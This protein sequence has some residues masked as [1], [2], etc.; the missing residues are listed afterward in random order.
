MHCAENLAQAKKQGSRRQTEQRRTEGG[1]RGAG[2]EELSWVLRES[3]TAMPWL[4]RVL[5]AASRVLARARAIQA[6][7]CT[8]TPRHLRSKNAARYFHVSA[9]HTH[10]TNVTK[11]QAAAQS[12]PPPAAS[13]ASFTERDDVRVVLG[14]ANLPAAGVPEGT[15]RR[16]ARVAAAQTADKDD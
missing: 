1:G 16:A 9:T 10:E 15:S 7:T 14:T 5:V 8:H 12:A 13:D 3:S 6:H 11:A 4:L 2:G